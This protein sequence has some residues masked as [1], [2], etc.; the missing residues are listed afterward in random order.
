MFKSYLKQDKVDPIP[1]QHY[2]GKETF[3]K[4]FKIQVDDIILPWVLYWWVPLS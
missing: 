3:Y 1:T 2:P 4:I